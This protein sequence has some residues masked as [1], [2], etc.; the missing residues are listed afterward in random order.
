MRNREKKELRRL[1][2]IAFCV[3]IYMAGDGGGG[4][5]KQIKGEKVIR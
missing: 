5:Y 2:I 3:F 4:E 1:S